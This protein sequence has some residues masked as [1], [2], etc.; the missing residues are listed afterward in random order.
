MPHRHDVFQFIL[1]EVTTYP[2]PAIRN[3]HKQLIYMNLVTAKTH[4]PN[5]ERKPNPEVEKEQVWYILTRKFCYND[6]GFCRE[7][8]E[9][10]VYAPDMPGDERK[11][12]GLGSRICILRL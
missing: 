11:G 5:H 8:D 9:R 1:F 3:R 12:V 6:S 4:Y 2:K 10:K 7:G